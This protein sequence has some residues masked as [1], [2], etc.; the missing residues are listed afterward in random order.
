MICYQVELSRNRQYFLMVIEKTICLNFLYSSCVYYND[1][2]WRK[3][4]ARVFTTR[5]L[6]TTLRKRLYYLE[7]KLATLD[8][9]D[10][11]ISEIFS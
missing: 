11:I 4:I 5:V 7:S 8:F 6:F 1:K 2:P 3:N 10:D 9:P